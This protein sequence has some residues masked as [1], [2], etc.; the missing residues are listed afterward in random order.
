MKYDVSYLLSNC[1]LT[2]GL[3]I[4]CQIISMH[5]GSD[6]ALLFANLFLYFYDGKWMNSL[7]KNDPVRPRKLCNLFRFTDDH[8]VKNDGGEF[9]INHKDIYLEELQLKKEK[10][11]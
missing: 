2:I 3:K 7:K 8:N 9:Q 10:F 4:I 1:F 6:S 11:R 5:T